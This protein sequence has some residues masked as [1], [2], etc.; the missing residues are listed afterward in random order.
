[1]LLHFLMFFYLLIMNILDIF[2]NQDIRSR[3]NTSDVLPPDWMLI[4]GK[5]PFMNNLSLSYETFNVTQGKKCI[6][7]V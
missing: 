6:R 4:N 5:G 2:F 3:L 1:M 7:E